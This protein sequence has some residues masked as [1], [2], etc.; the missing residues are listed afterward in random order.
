MV[1][2]LRPA[3]DLWEARPA[4]R[5]NPQSDRPA[6]THHAIKVEGLRKQDMVGSAKQHRCCTNAQMYGIPARP[7]AIRW[8]TERQLRHSHQGSANHARG[9]ATDSKTRSADR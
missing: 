5:Q 2:T 4:G 7:H 1:G 3:T 9:F 8:S 6:M